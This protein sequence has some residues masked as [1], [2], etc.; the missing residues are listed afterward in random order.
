MLSVRTPR[1]FR[2][3]DT[4]APVRRAVALAAQAWQLR[5]L[6]P[7]V[8]FFYVRA[9][10]TALRARDQWT[11]YTGTR[12]RELARLLELAGDEDRV[13]E[14]GTGT[15]CTA[16]ALALARR[17]RQVLTLDSEQRPERD[18]YLRLVGQRTRERI[19]FRRQRGEEGPP[20]GAG[21]FGLVFVDSSHEL[22]ETTATFAAWEPAVAR[23]GAVAFHDYGDP[24]YPG[25]EGA[26]RRLGLRGAREGSLYVWRKSAASG[27]AAQGASL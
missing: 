21:Q 14:V 12:P 1:L 17:D 20:A 10:L 24:L 11:L 7:R 13:A 15:G 19:E 18:R 8:A 6:P 9:L 25:V 26:I 2:T 27:A 22:E 5:R 3:E 16:I 23:G 4:R